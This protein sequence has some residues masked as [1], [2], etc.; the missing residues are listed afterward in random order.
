MFLLLLL[1]LLKIRGFTVIFLLS[2]CLPAFI[3]SFVCSPLDWA[4]SLCILNV[5]N[6]RDFLTSFWGCFPC[7]DI[8][9]CILFHFM[10]FLNLLSNLIF[11]SALDGNL[12]QNPCFLVHP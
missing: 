10:I 6:Q 11:E 9:S 2:E 3:I 4:I 1:L 5:L 8:V 7:E 12:L